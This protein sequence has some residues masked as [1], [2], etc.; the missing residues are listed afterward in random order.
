MTR[1]PSNDSQLSSD[2]PSQ[3]SAE[4]L[5]DRMML[6]TVQ[7]FAAG[8]TGEEV[9]Q[10]SIDDV[11]QAE[12][13]V[14]GGDIASR[15]FQEFT[16]DTPANISA[17]QVRI[18][19]I[20]D[21]FDPATG[22][23][24]NLFVDRIVIDGVTFETENPS[25]FSTGIY[26]NGLTGPGF[27]E[28]EILNING[29]FFFS[30]DG[31]SVSDTRTRIR[32]EAAGQVGGEEFRLLV[33]DQV[34][35]EFTAGTSQQ[36][37]FQVV[38]GDVSVDQIRIEFTNDLFDPGNGIDRNLIVEQ[39]QLIDVYS[40]ER[41]RF[42][43]DSQDVFST[44]TFTEADGIVPGFG[45][46][47]TLHS[48]GFLQFQFES[49]DP[50]DPVGATILEVLDEFN[51]DFP[52]FFPRF[53]DQTFTDNA[54]RQFRIAGGNNETFENILVV[55]LNESDA[56]LAD[57]SFGNGQLVAPELGEQVIPITSRAREAFERSGLA[58]PETQIVRADPTAAQLAFDSNNNIFIVLDVVAN[59][60]PRNA[61]PFD[62]IAVGTEIIKLNSNGQV[63]TSF[64]TDGRVF[65]PF[66]EGTSVLVQEVAFDD[67]DRLFISGPQIE[68]SFSLSSSFGNQ[69]VADTDTTLRFDGNTLVADDSFS[70][71]TDLTTFASVE[72]FVAANGSLALED[73]ES[74]VVNTGEEI[75]FSGQLN[76]QTSN[77]F[78]SPGDIAAGVTIG[79]PNG[80][81]IIDPPETINGNYES[82]ILNTPGGRTAVIEFDQPV[83]AVAF[84][85]Y[86]L[87]NPIFEHQGGIEVR[88]FEGDRLLNSFNVESTRV[89]FDNTPAFVGVSTDDAVIT[90]VEFEVSGAVWG[91]DNL[92]FG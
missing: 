13:V 62:G 46:G 73:F 66:E 25:T 48:N 72:D 78:I 3:L 15:D 39:I 8:Q 2:S 7:I 75:R 82:Q 38:D 35:S 85:A 4:L 88:A 32:I 60:T 31:A 18:E 16:F 28:T 14:T 63:D 21:A 34:V 20:N 86:S 51:Q 81:L 77:A 76:S 42:F 9:F 24:R 17:D 65:V 69:G 64:G 71:R 68:S 12:F 83:S 49:Q 57:S 30:N 70:F 47:N 37:F 80:E 87:N 19:F 90:R 43:F 52:G 33:D 53:V 5:E 1:F 22:Y 89:G 41:E 79:N 92:R 59:N 10:L 50:V 56:E 54:G 58:V 67:F 11:V 26:D 61:P 40:G 55:R 91:L 23:D 45:R 44:G 27:L 36:S 6:S 84:D 29:S 74:P